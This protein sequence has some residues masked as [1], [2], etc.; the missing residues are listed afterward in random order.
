MYRYAM[1]PRPLSMGVLLMETSSKLMCFFLLLFI[2]LLIEPTFSGRVSLSLAV[3]IL[4]LTQYGYSG[5]GT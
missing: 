2:I 1:L 3:R 5:A 4:K